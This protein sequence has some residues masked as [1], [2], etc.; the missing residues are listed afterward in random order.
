MSRAWV[1]RICT[2][3]SLSACSYRFRFS[4]R[5][6]NS[7]VHL[8]KPFL[9][10]FLISLLSFCTDAYCLEQQW[11][12]HKCFGQISLRNFSTGL[13]PSSKIKTSFFSGSSRQPPDRSNKDNSLCMQSI[14]LPLVPKIWAI[15]KDSMSW[16]V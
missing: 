14:Q 13:N 15:F 5:Q 11:L 16:R 4:C 3:Q 1:V 12:K 7:Y 6:P 8:S 10:R 2:A 9:W